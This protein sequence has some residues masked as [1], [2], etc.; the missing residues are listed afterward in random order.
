MKSK[1]ARM[2]TSSY[3]EEDTCVSYE[4]EDT[5]EVQVSQD[6]DLVISHAP[7]LITRT[8]SRDTGHMTPRH[9][10]RA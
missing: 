10:T 9:V 2:L 3:E 1:S 7:P 5:Y 4:E 6:A 8:A